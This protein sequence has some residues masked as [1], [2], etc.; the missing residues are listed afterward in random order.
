MRSVNC[1]GFPQIGCTNDAAYDM[2]GWQLCERCADN[3]RNTGRTTAPREMRNDNQALRLQLAACHE[4]IGSAL[5]LLRQE[6]TSAAMLVLDDAL[7]GTR[8]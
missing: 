5:A 3:W 7:K 4:A 6:Q 1:E 2:L 8:R